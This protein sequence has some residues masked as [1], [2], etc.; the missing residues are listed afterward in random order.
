MSK[1]EVFFGRYFP[2]F[3]LNTGKYGPENTSYLDTFHIVIDNVPDPREAVTIINGYEEIVKTQ[4]KK[5]IEYVAKQRQML[6]NFRD[7]EDFIK[8]V[9]LSRS[10][11]YFKL[12]LYK[13]L[14]KFLTLKKSTLSPHYVKNHFKVIRSDCKSNANIFS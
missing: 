6:K 3:G 12:G 10:S 1:Y 13:I 4:N 11:T 9:G 14:K 8:N 5:T 7:T 2:V